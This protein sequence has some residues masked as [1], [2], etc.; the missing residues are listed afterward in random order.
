VI[1]E[2][3]LARVARRAR[4]V[5]VVELNWKQRIRKRLGKS[6]LLFQLVARVDLEMHSVAVLALTWVNRHF[7]KEAMLSSL[8]FDQ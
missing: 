3:A 1:V 5:H 4:T 7:N 6:L 2:L 8:I